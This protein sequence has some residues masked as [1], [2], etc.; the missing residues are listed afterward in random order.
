MVKFFKYLAVLTGLFLC[1]SFVNA[2]GYEIKVKI[3][4]FKDSSLILG[5]YVAKPNAFLPDD[6]VKVSK[7]GIAVFKGKKELPKG[8]Y[9]L[10]F[11]NKRFIELL[12][13]GD[14][15]FSIDLDTLDLPK[16]V[17]FTGCDDNKIFYDNQN[18]ITSNREIVN[19]L[20]ERKKA[21]TSQTQKDSISK[22]IDKINQDVVAKQKNMLAANPGLYVTKL[23]KSAVEVE[24]P[25]FPRDAK[26]NVI[27]SAF[28]Y[29]YYKAHYF[30]NFNYADPDLFR[31]PMWEQKIKSYMENMVPPM[32]ADTVIK[33]LD[34]VLSRV[35]DN[36]Q[37]LKY[38]TFLFYPK[39]G[40]SQYM[41]QDA[42]FVHLGEKWILNSTWADSTLKANIQKDISKFKPNLIGA[43][44]PD[45]P[46]IEIPNDHFMLAQTDTA[47]RSNINV[48]YF[49]KLH[50]FKAKYLLVVFWESDCGHCK[51]IIPQ[52]H[53]MYP[54]LKD[55]GVEVLAIHTVASIEGK[56]K[57]VD[58]VNT[59]NLLDWHNAWSPTSYAYRDL[60]NVYSTPTIYLLDQNKK[61]I[62]KR[63]GPEQIEDF[64]KNDIKMANKQ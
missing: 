52:L 9:I 14:Q 36:E 13:G 64:I 22:A 3:P 60:Y 45:M 27:D 1:F 54:K 30:D 10:M 46:L 59:H 53:D 50:D 28:K 56:R 29:K 2:Q 12:M 58:F 32:P 48:G 16:H 7:A 34:I 17:V 47:Q 20:F 18:L 40:N 63:L 21:S 15:I 62:A 61:I 23:L 11:P 43:V 57:W 51:K 55:L 8:L 41:G 6:T 31:T 19:K 25:D 37:M 24:V 4:A 5:H 49:I 33:E 39:Y 44:A 35:K 38:L 26:G 42:I